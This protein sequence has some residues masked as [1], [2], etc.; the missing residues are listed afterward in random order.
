ME[1]LGS[2]IET[3]FV[4]ITIRRIQILP[5]PISCIYAHV[6]LIHVVPW[7]LCVANHPASSAENQTSILTNSIKFPINPDFQS[8]KNP[9]SQHHHGSFPE[10][11]LWCPKNRWASHPSR[12][13]FGRWSTVLCAL[14]HLIGWIGTSESQG[15]TRKMWND[16]DFSLVEQQNL[17]ISSISSISSSFALE[18]TA[19]YMVIFQP[20]EIC[21]W[22][23]QPEGSTRVW[24]ALVM[25]I[26]CY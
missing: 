5:L 4:K 14:H 12:H 26:S 8:C 24:R 21:V 7:I 15:F 6:A 2:P 10:M 17:G 11:A 16:G 18:I 23:N 9:L 20:T 3:H 22:F 1:S 13:L 25:I 19:I